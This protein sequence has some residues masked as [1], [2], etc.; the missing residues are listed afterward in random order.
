LEAVLDRATAADTSLLDL[1]QAP[2]AVRASLT[3]PHDLYGQQPTHSLSI[4]EG[5]EII[6]FTRTAT[7]ALPCASIRQN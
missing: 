6:L 5:A 3:A 7:P 4:G 1:R 2:T